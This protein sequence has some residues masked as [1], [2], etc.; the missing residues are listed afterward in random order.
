MASCEHALNAIVYSQTPYTFLVSTSV[1]H[2]ES[3]L[4]LVPS[5]ANLN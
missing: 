1:I 3:C 4:A 5:F 2:V